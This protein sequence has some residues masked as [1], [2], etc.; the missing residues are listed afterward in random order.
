MKFS[1]FS[2]SLKFLMKSNEIVN[3]IFFIKIISFEFNIKLIFFFNSLIKI[4]IFIIKFFISFSLL[5]S[6]KQKFIIS[7]IGK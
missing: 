7:S 3:F 2:K 5:L 1:I 4:F 6:L